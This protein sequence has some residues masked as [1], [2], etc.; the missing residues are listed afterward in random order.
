M[1]KIG[2]ALSGGGYRAAAFGLGV[3]MYLVDAKKNAE[4]VS[5]SSVSGGSVTNGFVAQMSARKGGRGYQHCD[6]AE[7]R[8]ECRRLGGTISHKTL[9][10]SPATWSYLALVL[11]SLVAA[12]WFAFGLLPWAWWA[13]FLLFLAL[14]MPWGWLLQQRG[15]IAGRAFAARL[16]S[17]PDGPTR[18]AATEKDIDHVLC[19][20]HLN[21]GEHFY[22]SGRF[23]YSYRFGWGR[24]GSL[25][26]YAAV[27]AS[28]AFPGGF[29]PRWMRTR[30]FAFTGGPRK[31]R[32]ATLS[33]GGV[34]DNLAD[35]WPADV[36][37]RAKERPDAQLQVPDE[38]VVVNSSAGMAWSNVRKLRIPLVGELLALLR[39]NSVMYNNAA[40]LRMQQLVGRFKVSDTLDGT[41]AYIQ[42]TPFSVPR[43]FSHGDSAEAQRAR[44]VIAALGG[45]KPWREIAEANE[46]VKT[47]LSPLGMTTTARLM[48]HAYVLAMANLHVILDYPWLDVPGPEYFEE[49]TR[50]PDTR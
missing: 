10:A 37:R 11:I 30:R 17:G 19:A 31:P 7:F 14:L 16:F 38:L 6:A 25:P 40:S 26:L 44:N 43:R 3:L 28:A 1:A 32:L 21:Q 34:Y 23:V 5:I 24:P 50:K 48:R 13:R 45:E 22:F 4:V 46:K 33:D 20:T 2:V 36:A 15:I 27:Q 47:T 35:Q 8:E 18:L 42:Q 12:A 49:L 29:P 9:W 41:L 39:V